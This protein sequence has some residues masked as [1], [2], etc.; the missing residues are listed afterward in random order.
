MQIFELIFIILIF[1]LPTMYKIQCMRKTDYSRRAKLVHIKLE[2]QNL[3]IFFYKYGQSFL[4]ISYLKT[5]LISYLTAYSLLSLETKFQH[6][7]FNI[8]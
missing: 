6:Y 8:L 5:Y 7:F 1:K 3:Y 4:T 2:I